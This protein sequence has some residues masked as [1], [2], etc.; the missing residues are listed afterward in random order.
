M[1]PLKKTEGF[2][3]IELMVAIAI[4]MVVLAGVTTT[5]ISQTRHYNAQEQVN[6]MEQNAR[7]ALD[8]ITRELKM[9]GYKPNG[10]TFDGVTYSTSQLMVQADLDSSGTI[11]TSSCTSITVNEQIT[12]AHDNTNKRIT[13][14]L[15]SGAAEVLADNITAFT[16][17]YLDANGASTTTTADIRQVSLNITARAAK[18]D[19]NYSSNGGYR[20]YLV[21]ATI[22]PPN[23]AL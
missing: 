8:V 16:F 20:E 5:F 21:T 3:L 6:E 10:G 7:G 1:H 14:A 23:L 19:P 4:G 22:T 9:A 12:Y 17:S 11:C 15:G 13:R 2:T 18:P